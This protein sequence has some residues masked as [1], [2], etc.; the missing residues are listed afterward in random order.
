MPHLSFSNVFFIFW[1]LL[2]L[3]LF[4]FNFPHNLI[5]PAGFST[6]S[7]LRSNHSVHVVNICWQNKFITC[8]HFT[9]NAV[10]NSPI[11]C[12]LFWLPSPRFS[13]RVQQLCLVGLQMCMFF[14]LLHGSISHYQFSQ[15]QLI[16]SIKH[17]IL[18]NLLF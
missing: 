8:W 2:K 10:S 9:H 6:I 12:L 16:S 3:I 4:L 7:L 11:I 15:F 13:T 1:P 18:L 5:R 17:P 14:P